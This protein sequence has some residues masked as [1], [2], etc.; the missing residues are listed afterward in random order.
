MR[1][2][3]Y[4]KLTGIIDLIQCA[5][6]TPINADKGLNSPLI[7]VNHRIHSQ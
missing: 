4:T 5:H 2:L 1:H 3:A 7:C 6:V